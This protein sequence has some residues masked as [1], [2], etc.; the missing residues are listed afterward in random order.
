MADLYSKIVSTGSYLL[1]IIQI[2]IL[3]TCDTSRDWIVERTGII[4]DTLP[5]KMVQR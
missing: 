1:K 2:M 5:M 4:V 3:K